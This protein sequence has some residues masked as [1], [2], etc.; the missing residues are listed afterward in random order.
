MHGP[1]NVKSLNIS[2]SQ[3]TT[4]DV[5]LIKAE[6]LVTFMFI[7]CMLRNKLFIIYAQISG[8]NLY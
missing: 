8:V 4:V 2:F 3:L 6:G 5:S 7:P 1:V